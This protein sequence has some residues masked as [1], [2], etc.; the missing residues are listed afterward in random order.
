MAAQSKNF[1]A[2][3]DLPKRHMPWFVR[4]LLGIVAIVVTI[5]VYGFFKI[6]AAPM[7]KL[8]VPGQDQPAETPAAPAP[9]R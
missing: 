6:A 8:E 2:S 3:D 1:Y 9:A 5:V 7:P 4:L